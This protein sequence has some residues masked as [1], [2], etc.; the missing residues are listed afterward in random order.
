MRSRTR[1][2]T[3][4]QL[5]LIKASQKT[6]NTARGYNWKLPSKKQ[7]KK[8]KKES[9]D[10]WKKFHLYI[11]TLTE[12][13]PIRKKLIFTHLQRAEFRFFYEFSNKTRHTIFRSFIFI[14]WVVQSCVF[15]F[16]FSGDFPSK[17]VLILFKYTW[18]NCAELIYHWNCWYR[19]H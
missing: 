14:Y 19:I 7:K 11:R 6:L 17:T 3:R 2:S 18:F 9:V 4:C 16:Q 5:D 13:N 1:L 12:P 15:F 8:W 10:H